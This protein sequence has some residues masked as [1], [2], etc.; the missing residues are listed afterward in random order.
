MRLPSLAIPTFIM[1]WVGLAS[2]IL[3][4]RWC[5]VLLCITVLGAGINEGIIYVG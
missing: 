3:M 4:M 1:S 5:W 2:L